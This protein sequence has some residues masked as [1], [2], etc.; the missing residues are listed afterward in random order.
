MRLASI[1]WFIVD[2]L[3]LTFAEHWGGGVVLFIVFVTRF[4][5]FVRH[6]VWGSG[7][8]RSDHVVNILKIH[9]KRGDWRTGER[10]SVAIGYF[11]K[12]VLQFLAIGSPMRGLLSWVRNFGPLLLYLRC[13]RLLIFIIWLNLFRDDAR[14][15]ISTQFWL[16]LAKHFLPK[17]LFLRIFKY[18]C[19]FIRLKIAHQACTIDRLGPVKKTHL[20]ISIA[21]LVN[22]GHIFLETCLNLLHYNWPELWLS[23]QTT[24][25]SRLASVI[26]KIIS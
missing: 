26:K 12:M 11:D 17:F 20:P 22:L 23:R 9:L 3:V 19:I 25:N 24:S 8:D 16:R 21:R 15:I 13:A 1:W 14:S 7:V 6:V 10:I 5:F 18:F 4:V 2:I